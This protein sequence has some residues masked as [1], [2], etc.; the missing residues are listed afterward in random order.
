MNHRKMDKHPVQN[1]SIAH[2][3]WPLAVLVSLLII[4]LIPGAITP[5]AAQTQPIVLTI[6][7]PTGLKDVFNDQI[8]KDFEAANPGIQV[9]VTNTV[10]VPEAAFGL[11][12]HLAALQQYASSADVLY[13]GAGQESELSPQGTRAGYFL[14]LAPLVN[15]DSSLNAGDFVP[16][17]WSALQWDNGIWGIPL[18]A[19][20]DLI[21]YDPAAFDRA[22]L[23]YPSPD[24]SA[25]EFLDTVT[26]LTVK[27]AQGNIVTPGFATNGGF[28]REIMMRA[29]ISGNLFDSSSVPNPPALDQAGVEAA[30]QTFSQM[31]DQ[32]LIGGDPSTAPMSIM[33]AGFLVKGASS[34]PRSAALLP[35]GSVY[36]ETQGLAISAGTQHPDA[37]YALIKFISQRAE[38]ARLGDTPAR[39]SQAASQGGQGFAFS[40]DVQT[41]INQGLTNALNTSNARFADYL[42]IADNN[43]SPTLDAKT[44]IQNEQTQATND[45]NAAAAQK[46][47]LALTVNEPPP[48]VV[49]PGKITL[50]FDVSAGFK[51]GQLPTQDQWTQFIA[52]FVAHDP[53]VGHVTLNVTNHNATDAASHSDCFYQDQNGVPSLTENTVLTLDPYLT[54]DATFDRND[55]LN[56]VLS[57]VQRDDKTWALPL[58]IEPLVI[59][60]DADKFQADSLPS[61][62]NGWTVESFTDALTHLKAS[63]GPNDTA[64]FI[65]GGDGAALLTLIIDFGG[66]PIDYRTSPVTI[67]F[68][69]PK[70]VTAIQEVLDMA[71]SG[72]IAYSAMGNL[73][74]G[75]SAN[76][77]NTTA[78]FAI[79][80]NN[81]N[82]LRGNP[83]GAA[84]MPKNSQIALFP[85]GHDTTGAAY[86]LGMAYISATA[87]NPDACY[88][89]IRALADHPELFWNMP[90]RQSI[91][92]SHSYQTLTDTDT[93]RIY[94]QFAALLNDPHTIPMPELGRSA[95]AFSALFTQHWLFEAFDAYVLNHADLGTALATADQEAKGFLGCIANL[96]PLSPAGVS[97]TNIN[98]ARPYADCAERVEPALKPVLDP[99]FATGS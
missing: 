9:D 88:R 59:V 11:T 2:R 38:S 77:D 31:Q 13:I 55:W 80:L 7:L 63:A 62:K 60:Y 29:L 73:L 16:A 98:A 20:V 48:V 53:L 94:T 54:A 15:A 33:P 34:T 65:G 52:Q 79:D 19:N 6:A 21:T 42:R 27:D 85:T 39:K 81:L 44:A 66:L 84:Q 61:P 14:D 24:W 36:L 49:A 87:Q 75:S 91:L 45:A 69:D 95:P 76:W 64:P 90:A 96:P 5:T 12:A 32:N 71:K 28:S 35:G 26:K 83:K 41:V 51:G 47:T 10:G 97:S 82:F 74:G 89:F 30:V 43:I 70:T 23:S 92:A 22:K 67:N 86:N 37:A 40:A 3:R 1:R 56:G 17:I 25:A 68:T 58:T 18:A 8:L 72:V 78:L 46:G 57:A 50:T 93:L 99:L 4:T